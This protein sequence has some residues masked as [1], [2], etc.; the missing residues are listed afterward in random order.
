MKVTLCVQLWAHEG[1]EAALIAYEDEVLPMIPVHGGTVLQRAR[2]DGADGAPLEV[3]LIQFPF[4]KALD[5]YM[6]DPR[7]AALADARE[8]A[9]A[10]TEIIR[11]HLV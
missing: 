3:H 6:A 10:R 11:V 4:Q 1:R 2:S 7:R 8:K 5:S 9:I